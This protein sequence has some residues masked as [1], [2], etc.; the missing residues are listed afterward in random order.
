MPNLRPSASTCLRMPV[1]DG[2]AAMRR[3]VV[4]L[5]DQHED[6]I[7]QVALVARL[8]LALLGVHARVV[9]AA[10]QRRHDDLLVALVDLVELEDGALPRLEHLVQVEM[11]NGSKTMLLLAQPLVDLPV[12]RRDG[13][14]AAVV[15][16][17]V[18]LAAARPR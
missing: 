13:A 8:H 10:Q 3:E 11:W 4:R 15:A 14:V 12:Q 18:V 17:I 16:A 2:L 1:R 5:L 6:G 9:D 7:G